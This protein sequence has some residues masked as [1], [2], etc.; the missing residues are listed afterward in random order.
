[1]AGFSQKSLAANE[2]TTRAPATN[3]GDLAIHPHLAPP[4]QTRAAKRAREREGKHPDQGGQ[5]SDRKDARAVPPPLMPPAANEGASY[6]D[7]PVNPERKQELPRSLP[8]NSKRN[9]DRNL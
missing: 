2:K 1:M 8:L 5:E 9:A 6:T 7:N 4:G 3:P